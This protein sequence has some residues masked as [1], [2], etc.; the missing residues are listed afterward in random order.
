MTAK[1][2]PPNT[3]TVYHQLR[4]LLPGGTS[5]SV[6]NLV[7]KR[8]AATF[9]FSRGDFAFYGEVN[10]KV[11]GAVFGGSG[12]LHITPPTVVERHSL[13]I[14]T[15]QSAFDQ[16]FSVLVL[17][18]TDNTSEE[19]RKSAAAQEQPHS[20]ESLVR[21]AAEFHTFQ[22]EKLHENIDL[23]L[24]EDVLNPADL[25]AKGF[26]LAEMKGSGDSYTLFEIDP[27]GAIDVAPE[28]V[29][30]RTWNSWGWTYPAAFHLAHEYA[31]GTASS[32]EENT[33]FKVDHEDLETA[34]EKSGFLSGTAAVHLYALK[35][36]V[37]VVPFALFPTLR[38]SKVEGEHN[39]VLDFI[40]ERK[41]DDPDFGLVL[42][43]PLKKGEAALVHI[44]YGGKDAVHNVGSDN[45]D[46]VA[47]ESWF[48]N[49]GIGFG[50]Y[51]TYT[52]RF[53]TPKEV[54]FIATGSKTHDSVDG[55]IR[56]TDWDTRMPLP[57][58]GFHLGRFAEKEDKTPDGLTVTAYAN[59][60]LPDWASNIAH[61]ANGDSVGPQRD[62]VMSG[63]A[64]GNL[65]TTGM[66][67]VELSQ[68]TAAVQI[69]TANFGK[70]SFDHLALS[71][72]PAC[73]Y[74]QSWPMLVY[75]P[76]CG[77]WDGTIQNQFGLRP[78]D[79]YWKTVTAHEVAHQWWGHTVGFESYRDQ[80][81]SEGFASASAAMFLQATR[82]TPND[83]RDFWKQLKTQ[84]TQ[85]NQDGFRPVDVGPVT[86]GFRLSSPRTGWSVYNNL[87]YPKGAY[88]LHMIRMMMYSPRTGDEDFR[89]MMHDFVDTYRLKVATTEDFKAI[90]EKHMTPNMDIDRNHKMDWFFNEY[91]YGIQLP[92]YHFES[93][94]DA[95]SDTI[96]LHFKL[97]QSGVSDSFE[98]L[99]PV[100]IELA[101]GRVLRLGQI[102]IAGNNSS[103]QSVPMAKSSVPIKRISIDYMHDVLAI[104]N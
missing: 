78:D 64:V 21:A 81:M 66:L 83:Y 98:M 28:E 20:N 95:N 14:L 5:I 76:I 84:L 86:M 94:I 46:P 40:Q 67:P 16:D 6:N 63:M 62:P 30:L 54:Q 104:E 72:Q 77:F 26:F 52:M 92:Q 17:R 33:A 102:P 82:K 4:D 38:V 69:Y 31:E 87:V 65:N 1:A 74:G 22:R 93:Q 13:E 36:G 37:T 60:D 91:V 11:T 45:Y 89:A 68:G 51:T 53:H 90:V 43:H 48:P 58:V 80:W 70:L 24:L 55:R 10:G 88:I 85:K 19:L 29:S 57:V 71:Q 50:G 100:Y 56:T 97:T 44:T 35:D 34:I 99:V 12:H 32:R 8:D 42:A 23:R 41:E 79:P 103:E 7:L 39:E 15:K 3:N 18:F 27:Q 9:T 2:Q 25:G 75:L 73:N 49:G 96:N 47:R 61:A 101:D 59:S